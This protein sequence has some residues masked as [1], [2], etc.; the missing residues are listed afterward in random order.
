MSSGVAW[1]D[2]KVAAV[3]GAREFLERAGLPPVPVHG[4]GY[5]RFSAPNGWRV[6]GWVG[7]LNDAQL[8][9][10]AQERGFSG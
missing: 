7:P 3:R 6:P 8:L 1:I 2:Q 4:A 5:G 10:F 9:A